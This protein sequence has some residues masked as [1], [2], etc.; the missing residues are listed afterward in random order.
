MVRAAVRA[1]EGQIVASLTQEASLLNDIQQLKLQQAALA[2]GGPPNTVA[3]NT[4][5]QDPHVDAPAKSKPR[6]AKAKTKT[7]LRESGNAT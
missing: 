4:A 2:T 6:T 5:Q 1:T 3:S 7:G